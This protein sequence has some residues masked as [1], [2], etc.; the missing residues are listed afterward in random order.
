MEG[1]IVRFIFKP[2]VAGKERIIKKFLWLPKR[3]E[4]ELR[5]LE[6]VEIFQKSVNIKDPDYGYRV[7]WVDRWFF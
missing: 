7:K 1:L 3:L 2:D 5:W 4:N 6:T